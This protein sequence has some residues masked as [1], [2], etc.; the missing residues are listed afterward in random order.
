[1]TNQS[2]APR[3][4][5]PCPWFES[6]PD[7]VRQAPTLVPRNSACCCVECKVLSW[8]QTLWTLDAL[9]LGRDFSDVTCVAA[10]MPAWA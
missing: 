7:R 10:M 1:M 9:E 8:K 4:L 2:S 5:R 3:L 6:G